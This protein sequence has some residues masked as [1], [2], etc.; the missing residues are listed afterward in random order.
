MEDLIRCLGATD[1]I[2][3]DRPDIQAFAWNHAGE[4][5]DPA[6]KAAGILIRIL[7]VLVLLP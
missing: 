5:K 3:C 6:E 4:A 2:D 7:G 1:I